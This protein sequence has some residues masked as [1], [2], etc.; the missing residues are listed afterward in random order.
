MVADSLAHLLGRGAPR[1]PD[2]DSLDAW[3][4]ALGAALPRP[5]VITLEGDLGT[6]KTTLA[7][8]LCAGLGV[9]ALDAVTS[10]TFS[11]V[12]Q[13]DAPRGPIVHADLYRLKGPADLE[14]L[15]WD[16]LVDQSPVL[17]V[18]WPDRAANM[19]PAD[20]IGITLAHDPEHPERRLLKVHV[21]R[22][23]A[24]R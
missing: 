14:A 16:E 22:A 3:G 21:P 13:Y 23:G 8:A 5:T 18:E 7:R 2:R 6:G 4:K 10:P 1:N 20:A 9:L 19:L 15:G 11:L 24:A 17:L 12:Q